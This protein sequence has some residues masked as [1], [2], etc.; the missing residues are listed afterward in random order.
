MGENPDSHLSQGPKPTFTSR[1]ADPNHP[2]SSG[3]PLALI[4]GGN[5]TR[6][7]LQGLKNGRTRGVGGRRS[8]LDEPQD[9]SAGSPNSSSPRGPYG[10]RLGLRDAV[11]LA[12]DIRNPQ[13]SAEYSARDDSL[14][15]RLQ[16]RTRGQKERSGL[17]TPISKLLKKVMPSRLSP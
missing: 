13:Q 11:A 2:A 15:G 6:E 3:D 4:T 5:I 12:K 1:Y 9:G 14:V 8:Y 7:K 10:R 16:S 17:L